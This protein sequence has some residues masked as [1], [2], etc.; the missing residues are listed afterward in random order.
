MHLHSEL[1][2]FE[3]VSIERG[4]G[5]EISK[6]SVF[7]HSNDFFFDEES[8]EAPMHPQGVSLER[9]SA[10]DIDRSERCVVIDSTAPLCVFEGFAP[11]TATLRDGSSLSSRGELPGEFVCLLAPRLG[12]GGG[13]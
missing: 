2:E 12:R 7:D 1:R 11:P 8:R 6:F 5:E 9:A 10:T 3:S 4:N 13:A